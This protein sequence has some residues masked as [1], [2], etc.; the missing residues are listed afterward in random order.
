MSTHVPG[1]Q[2]LKKI[3]SFFIGHV[4]VILVHDTTLLT[5]ITVEEEIV[6]FSLWPPKKNSLDIHTYMNY[7]YG[8]SFQ[9]KGTLLP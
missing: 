3:A 5:G 8:Q 2:P 1:F 9:S 4:D 7:V 6:F